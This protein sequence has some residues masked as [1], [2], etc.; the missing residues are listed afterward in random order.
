MSAARGVVYYAVGETSRREAEAS[1]ASLKQH[2]PELPV[3]LFRDAPV[4][5]DLF[6]RQLELDAS[7]PLWALKIRVLQQ[8]PFERTLYLDADTFVCAPVWE[9]FDLLDRAELAAAVAPIWSVSNDTPRGATDVDGVPMAF[10][11][12]NCGV[13]AFRQ[14]DAMRGFLA[15][16]RSRHEKNGLETSDQDAFREALYWSDVRFATL[17][18]AYN[19]RLTSPQHLIGHAKILHGRDRDLAELAARLNASERR[20]LS[21]PRRYRR[22]AVWHGETGLAH[23]WR[24]WLRSLTLRG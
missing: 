11:K 12:Y 16:W 18:H 20:R 2:M 4:E 19:Y 5:S 17:W 24:K 9:I 8:S 21:S 14:G 1:A 13:I 15:D 6:D 23:A 22:R 10:P 7:V 3:A